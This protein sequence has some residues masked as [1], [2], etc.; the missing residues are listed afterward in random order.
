MISRPR[1]RL[2]SGLD[3]NLPELIEELVVRSV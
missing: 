1:G 3:K 2:Y